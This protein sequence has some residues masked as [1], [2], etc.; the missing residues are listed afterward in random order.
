MGIRRELGEPKEKDL[1]SRGRGKGN[2]AEEG[3]PGY[4]ENLLSDYRR[5]EGR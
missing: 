1:E 5:K 3:K 4:R 2:T